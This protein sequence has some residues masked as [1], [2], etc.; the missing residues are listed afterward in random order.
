MHYKESQEIFN[1]AKKVHNR[2]VFL[3]QGNEF[4]F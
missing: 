4:I 2:L 1:E 3:I